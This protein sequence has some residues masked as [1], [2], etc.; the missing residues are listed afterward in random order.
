MVNVDGQLV[1]DQN[2]AVEKIQF[3]MGTSG[4]A[5]ATYFLSL[6]VNELKQVMPF[7]IY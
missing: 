1:L 5:A 3:E 2:T 6:Q 7:V 4:L